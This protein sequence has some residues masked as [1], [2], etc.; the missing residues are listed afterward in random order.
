[1]TAGQRMTSTG[2]INGNLYHF[3]T[4]MPFGLCF[5]NDAGTQSH[6]APGMNFEQFNGREV[7]TVPPYTVNSLIGS[8]L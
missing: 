7:L 4:N 6:L 8:N 5:A 1:M 2:G 3:A